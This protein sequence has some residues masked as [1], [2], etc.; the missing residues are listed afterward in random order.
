MP[1]VGGKLEITYW[2]IWLEGPKKPPGCLCGR[3]NAVNVMGAGEQ[4][5]MGCSQGLT[6]AASATCRQFSI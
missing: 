4:L 5:N 2:S 6:V 1:K 3:S